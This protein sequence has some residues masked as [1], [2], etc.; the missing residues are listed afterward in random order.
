MHLPGAGIND[1]LPDKA[2]KPGIPVWK[3]GG[4]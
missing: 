2:K 1:N 4:A 3:F